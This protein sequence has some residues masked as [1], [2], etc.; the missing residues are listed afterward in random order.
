VRACLARNHATPCDILRT[1]ATDP[2]ETVRAFVAINHSV[3]ADAMA[4]LAQDASE[5]VQRLV[6]WKDSLRDEA[7][8]EAEISELVSL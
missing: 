7:A 8:K 4:L 5:T 2:C 3:P 6:E 1:L